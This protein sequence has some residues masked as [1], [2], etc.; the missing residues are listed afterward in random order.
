MRWPTS[1]RRGRGGKGRREGR[2]GRE[3]E[4]MERREGKGAGEKEREG[5]VR[6]G[7]NIHARTF[8][9]SKRTLHAKQNFL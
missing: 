1:I 8:S 5:E 2:R 9:F 3:G 4:G 6:G 7:F